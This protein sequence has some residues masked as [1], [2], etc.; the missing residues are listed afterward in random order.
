MHSG[1][2]TAAFQISQGV[3]PMKLIW[4]DSPERHSSAHAW[5]GRI[6][7]SCDVILVVQREANG[8]LTNGWGYAEMARMMAH[9]ANLTP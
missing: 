3:T 2:T 8:K 4:T 1:G 9:F 6:S 5:A 7:F